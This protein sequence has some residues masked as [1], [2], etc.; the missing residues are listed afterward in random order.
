M[1]NEN[2]FNGELF[3]RLDGAVAVS[4]P[5]G[6]IPLKVGGEYIDLAPY[7]RTYLALGAMVTQFSKNPYDARQLVAMQKLASQVRPALNRALQDQPAVRQ[8]AHPMVQAMSSYLQSSQSLIKMRLRTSYQIARAPKILVPISMSIAAGGTLTGVQ[9]RNPY[10][11]A[12]GGMT[13]QYQSPWAITSFRT[14]N[15]ESG[16]LLPI[17]I[18]QFLLGGHDFVAAALAGL[19]YTAGGAP[20]TQGWGAGAFAETKRGNWKTEVQPWNVVASHGGGT[21]FG[22][23]MTETGFLQIGVFNGG[24]QTYVDTYSVYCNATLCGSPFAN[25][26]YTQVDAF[27]KSFAPLALQAPLSLALAGAADSHLDQALDAD[28]PRW[29]NEPN[30]WMGKVRDFGGFIDRLTNTPGG[31]DHMAV[32]TDFLDPTGMSLAP[33][34]E[35]VTR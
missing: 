18:T 30:S 8:I 25:A 24:A 16:A 33:G 20:A 27:R 28:D 32:G 12:S 22:S 21:G 11:G 34:A 3:P 23:V 35:Y 4:P 15:G 5:A 31:F 29:T 10:L 1:A 26:A 17:R 6:V 14:S 9:V 13:G 7:T 2:A 19:T